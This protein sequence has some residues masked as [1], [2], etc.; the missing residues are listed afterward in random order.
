VE[1][2]ISV[3]TLFSVILLAVCRLPFLCRA[4]RVCVH[5]FAAGYSQVI[6]N[7]LLG[8]FV[9][10]GSVNDCSSHN[11]GLNKN[12]IPT[13]LYFKVTFM[14]YFPLSIHYFCLCFSFTFCFL[15]FCL[16][17]YMRPYFR[18]PK[19][20]RKRKPHDIYIFC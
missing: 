13:E 10:N 17:S 16:F 2:C 11:A 14:V 12:G 20:C 7:V 9:R 6:T 1:V 3:G 4:V 18:S 15:C 5:V 8:D 19:S